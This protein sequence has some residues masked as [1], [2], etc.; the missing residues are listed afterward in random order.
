MN[1]S[2]TNLKQALP[3]RVAAVAII[4]V[5]LVIIIAIAIPFSTKPKREEG[6][7]PPVSQQPEVD[8]KLDV[9]APSSQKSKTSLLRLAKSLPYRSSSRASTGNKITFSI[10]TKPANEYTLYVE[11]IPINFQS[12]YADPDL[13]Q[14]VL[15]FRETA[16][17][18][19]TWLQEQKVSPADL[20]ISW[21]SRAYIQKAAEA[22]LLESPQF[23]KVI[24]KGDKF[25]FEKEPVKTG[26]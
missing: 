18:I 23:P 11:M 3:V 21:G 26:P 22:W 7:P 12:T 19:F 2:L 6:V 4:L 16:E 15:D 8:G 20:F 25:I 24:K 1:L 13:A 10:Y 5:I 9:N 14:N 17:A